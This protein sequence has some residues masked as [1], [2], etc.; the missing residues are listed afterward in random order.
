MLSPPDG[1]D[2][3][4]ARVPNPN[5]VSPGVIREGFIAIR[6]YATLKAVCSP[7]RAEPAIP[8][9]VFA[10]RAMPR[11]VREEHASL[12]SILLFVAS[13]SPP[14]VR[15]FWDFSVLLG[16]V[17][18]EPPLR[19][20]R[21]VAVRP[22][23]PRNRY[24]R[25]EHFSRVQPWDR[26]AVAIAMTTW[27]PIMWQE[28]R[29]YHDNHPAFILRPSYCGPTFGS[30]RVCPRRG[31]RIAPTSHVAGPSV[32]SLPS[33]PG[34]AFF[35]PPPRIG[36]NRPR[37]R[38]A[39]AAS[40]F[41]GSRRLARWRATLE[42]LLRASAAWPPWRALA[43]RQ[44][45]DSSLTPH[46]AG[47][48]SIFTD[49]RHLPATRLAILF[50]GGTHNLAPHRRAVRGSRAPSRTSPASKGMTVLD[51]VKIGRHIPCARAL[52]PAGYYTARRA[53]EELAIAPR[54][55]ARSSIFG[56][57]G[58]RPKVVGT[59]PYGLQSGGRPGAGL[60]PFVLLLD[61]RRGHERG[62]TD[63][64]CLHPHVST[65]APHVGDDRARHGS[66]WTS[67][68]AW[69]CSTSAKRS[70]RARPPRSRRTPSW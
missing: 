23:E 2:R 46:C 22:D 70:P 10:S 53:R 41:R 48:T 58:H 54:S 21:I 6:D 57:A 66:L 39:T 40:R 47:K 1:G 29:T 28:T 51:N 18:Q 25:A 13:P 67:P 50:N 65:K 14:R 31:P 33:R 9:A 43:G 7:W 15:A 59:L 55:S 3:A 36:S 37:S 62:E 42:D 45:G 16:R 35:L 49:Q 27:P 64:W 24:S 11:R 20:G 56:A 32:S 60:E 69:P 8:A 61:D 12:G 52:S 26:S 4:T 30:R 34:C 5:P 38:G 44:H 63:D 17:G 68:T 19:S